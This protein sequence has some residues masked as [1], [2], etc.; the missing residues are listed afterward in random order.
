MA[1]SSPIPPVFDTLTTML[2]RS[3]F[4]LLL[5]SFVPLFS[6]GQQA[7]PPALAGAL[8]KSGLPKE[9]ESVTI[10]LQS[11]F[12][13]FILEA[14]IDGKPSRLILDTG[15]AG[16]ILT[17]QAARNLN[18]PAL[19]R[20]MNVVDARGEQLAT[21]RTLTKRISLGNAWT[22]NE[23]VL[24]SEL[25]TGVEGAGI[26]GVLGVSTLVDWDVRI[27]PSARELILFPAG[28]AQNLAGE[29]AIPLTCD[30]ANPAAGTSTPQAYRPI[31][32]TV[33]VRIG[34]HELAATPD[35]GD[36]GGIFQLSSVLVEKFLP[37]VMTTA[38]P[39]L[40]R[41]ITPSG[42]MATRTVRLPEFTFGPDT[43]KDLPVDVLNAP[44]DSRREREGIIG[45]NLLRHYVMTF[46]FSAGEL[47]LKPLGTVQEIT[48]ASTAG[49]NMDQ[50]NRLL[51]VVPDGPADKAGLR[52]GDELLEIEGHA[53]KT[54]TPEEFAA[55]KRLPPGSVVKVRYRRGQSDPVDVKLVL[56]K[57]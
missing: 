47:R 45:L 4:L 39:A 6:Q 55:F 26:A 16:T 20:G 46:R 19:V 52:V 42:K 49:I 30:L 25:I 24:I 44:P 31:N 35:T 15:A 50:D 48:R 7:I 13:G 40:V 56:E 28:K 11:T 54:M 12:W 37:E 18:L 38:Q 1:A 21:K 9:T 33:P 22:E 23:P 29:T 5:C 3:F 57:K 32:L 27:D 10:P 43:L 51:S 34:K 2:S 53:L 14:R 41:G 8:R 17:P 36:G